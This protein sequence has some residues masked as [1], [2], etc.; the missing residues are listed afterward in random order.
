VQ[1]LSNLNRIEKTLQSG[2]WVDM[3]F[4]KDGKII[5]ITQRNNYHSC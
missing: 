3:V 1:A 5:G 2:D 4:N